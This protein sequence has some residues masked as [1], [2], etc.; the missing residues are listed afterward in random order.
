MPASTQSLILS[1]QNKKNILVADI[2]FILLSVIILLSI[3]TVFNNLSFGMRG[4]VALLMNK[5]IFLNIPQDN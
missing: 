1:K 5:R 2:T 4:Y 3:I